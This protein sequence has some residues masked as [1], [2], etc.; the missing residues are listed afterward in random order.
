ML[1]SADVLPPVVEPLWSTPMNCDE[2]PPMGTVM[3]NS[4]WSIV[5]ASCSAAT[6]AAEPSTLTVPA[7]VTAGAISAT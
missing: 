6:Y 5:M 3:S 1:E 2:P 4:P 7:C